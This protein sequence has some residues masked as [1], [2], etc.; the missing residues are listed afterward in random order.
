M[1][2]IAAQDE[3]GDLGFDFTKKMTSK[4][5]CITLVVSTDAKRMDKIVKRTFADFKMLH[6]KHPRGILHAYSET[7]RTNLSVLRRLKQTDA[8]VFV[9]KVDKTRIVRRDIDEF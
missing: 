3:S 6:I 1:N 9:I 7:K 5:F 2:Y 8:Q 4:H